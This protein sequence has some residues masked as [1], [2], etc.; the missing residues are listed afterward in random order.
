MTVY[1][2][3]TNWWW[4]SSPN[5][6]FLCHVKGTA[7]FC[8]PGATLRDGSRIICVGASSA[9]IVAPSCTEVGFQ[10]WAGGQYNSTLVGNKCCVSEWP[11]LESQLTS[12]G[13][14]PSDWCVPSQSDL[15][16]GYCCR[17]YW[18]TFSSAP[19]WSSTE[20]SS[21][22]ASSVFFNTCYQGPYSKTATGC[23]RAFRCVTY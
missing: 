3:P 19:Y 11:G 10:Q 23:V 2:G 15:V 13:F 18:D 22:T 6:P 16:I 14:T 17:T 8:G 21:I 9:L 12:C 20:N 5:A 4:A 1:V 7:R